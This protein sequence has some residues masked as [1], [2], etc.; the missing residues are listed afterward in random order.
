MINQD[1]GHNHVNTINQPGQSL[2]KYHYYMGFYYMAGKANRQ[3]EANPLF[4][5]AT[6][7]GNMGLSCLLG[8][9][10]FVPAKD[11]LV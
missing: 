3:D 10:R 11:S 1:P 6:R 2:F 8:I 7:P 5:L 4:W 9:S